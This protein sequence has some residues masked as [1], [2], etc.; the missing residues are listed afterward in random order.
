M[1]QNPIIKNRIKK[2]QNINNI[3][4]LRFELYGIFTVLI[5]SKEVFKSN[6][7]IKE[8]IEIFN[9]KSKPYMIKSRSIIL[10][11]VIR[12]I[13]DLDDREIY[14]Y[15]SNLNKLFSDEIDKKVKDKCKEGT[16]DKENYMESL[17]KKYSRNKD[18]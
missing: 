13:R 3:E 11:K 2:V 12:T 10:S 15:I 8:F 4:Q 18:L 1:Y 14:I 5:L 6:K 17:L 7:D 9:I 16:N